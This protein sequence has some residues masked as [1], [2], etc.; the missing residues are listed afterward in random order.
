MY[1]CLRRAYSW[2]KN[3]DVND[4]C[5]FQVTATNFGTTSDLSYREGTTQEIIEN[6][7]GNSQEAFLSM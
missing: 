4:G 3:E 5:C 7:C 1:E 2:Q 6:V